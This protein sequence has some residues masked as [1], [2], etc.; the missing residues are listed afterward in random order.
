MACNLGATA[1]VVKDFYMPL[2]KSSE[3][4]QIYAV[5]LIAFILGVLPV[6]FALYLPGLLKT[7]FFA[8]ALRAA[9]AVI[10]VFWFYAPRFGSKAGVTVGL[11]LSIAFTTT[12]F[13]LKDP[14]G[15]D[16]MYI[17]VAT[18][19]LCMCV[20][21]IFKKR[22]PNLPAAPGAPDDSVRSVATKVSEG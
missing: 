20:S 10:V 15:I 4:H 22:T 13:L 9:L 17:A 5:R 3:K 14:F 21:H 19:L 12:W 2:F 7:I 8:R 16:N 6:P 1:L 11:T 18:P